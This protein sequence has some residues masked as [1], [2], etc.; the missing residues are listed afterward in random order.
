M[1]DNKRERHQDGYKDRESWI[2]KRYKVTDT[3]AKKS[4]NDRNNKWM[5]QT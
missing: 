3:H 2:K 4:M 5:K 1:I